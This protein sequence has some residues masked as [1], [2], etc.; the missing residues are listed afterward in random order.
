MFKNMN[1]GKKMALAFGIVMALTVGAGIYAVIS[2]VRVVTYYAQYVPTRIEKVDLVNDTSIHLGKQ[3]REWKNMLLRGS[4]PE[5]LKAHKEKF[6]T[7][8]QEVKKRIEELRNGPYKLNSEA[9]K[10]KLE[11]FAK[12][13]NQLQD[14]YAEALKIYAGGTEANI[15]AADAYVKGK[16]K[17]AADLLD[18]IVSGSKQYTLEQLENLKKEALSGGGVIFIILILSLLIGVIVTYII[19]RNISKPLG[20]VSGRA[21][22]IAE[23]DLTGEKLGVASSDEVGRLAEAFNDMVDGLRNIVRQV[24]DTSD[25]VS[26]AGQQLSSSAQEMNATA[27]EV[28]STVQQIAKG[29]ETTAQRVEQTS[30]VIEE[31][32]ASVGQVATSSQQAATASLQTNQAAQRG[33]AAVKETVNKMNRIYETVTSSAQVVKKLGERSEQITEIVNVI[34]NVA[35]QTNLLALNAAIE[36]ARAGEAGRGFAVVAE[37]VRKLAEGSAKAADQIGRLIKEVQ[38]E[39]GQ[40]VEA[41]ELGSKEVEEGREVVNKTGEALTEIMKLAENTAS[42]VQQISAASQQLSSGA[43]QVLKSVDDIAA[44]AEEAASATEEASA[45]TEEMTASME[46]LSAASQELS[47]MAVGLRELVVKFKVNEDGLPT[48][49]W[50]KASQTPV[51]SITEKLRSN[52][53]RLEAIRKKPTKIDRGEPKE[54]A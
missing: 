5:A 25:Q 23:G 10:Q 31:M 34:T 42:M 14:E 24:M 4:D 38:K 13:Y 47:E 52:R 19:T 3:T 11:E 53:E 43:K 1:V 54:K 27:Q 26:T 18:E 2:Y 46:E 40:A 35:D 12:N 39:T 7:E 36:A 20:E 51:R 8:D 37:E 16:D 49:Q 33:G 17:E 22:R 32:N 30:K 9:N 45:S 41:M 29:S 15:K 6:S 44:T 48:K 28:S 21:K 50:A